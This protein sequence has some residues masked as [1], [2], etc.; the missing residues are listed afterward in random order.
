[1]LV[2][3]PYHYALISD[4]AIY[5]DGVP[6][7]DKFGQVKNLCGEQQVRTR[8]T[9]PMPFPL[10]PGEK[11]E[12]PVAPLEIVPKDSALKLKVVV[13]VSTIFFIVFVGFYH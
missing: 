6:V 2:I 5:Q 9:F 8:E 7:V 13:V 10:C 4:P 12:Q 11:L 1:M 3:P